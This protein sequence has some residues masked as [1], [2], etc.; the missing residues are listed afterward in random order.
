MSIG[1][2]HL[3]FCDQV[4]WFVP[5]MTV[6]ENILFGKAFDAKL[7]SEVVAACC[8]DHDLLNLP[9]GDDTGLASNGSPLSGG[10]RKRV[11]LART[12]YDE[13]GDFLLLDDV[14]SGLDAKTMTQ[15]AVNLFG[16]DGFLQKRRAAAIFC[17]TESKAAN[18]VL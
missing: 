18:Y 3:T 16:S 15:V 11:S 17:C 6:K 10:Q 8:L 12:L 2:K 5:E 9:K 7:Y 14:F 4:P 13:G 1:A